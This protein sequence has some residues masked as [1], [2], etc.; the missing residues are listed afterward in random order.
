ME[1]GVLALLVNHTSDRS[2]PYRIM[3]TEP[4]RGSRLMNVAMYDNVQVF[5]QGHEVIVKILHRR[6]GA[7]DSTTV[8]SS[9]YT[10]EMRSAH[11][12]RMFYD[13]VFPPKKK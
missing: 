3:V 7:P 13:T 10:L 5:Q 8:R 11:D 4:D 1:K 9:K 6:K 2:Y 12:A